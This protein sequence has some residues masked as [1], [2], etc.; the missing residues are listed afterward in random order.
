MIENENNFN[1][2]QQQL[3]T[4]IIGIA[5]QYICLLLNIWN[6]CLHNYSHYDL[7]LYNKYF[8]KK[9]VPKL[10]QSLELSPPF[11]IRFEIAPP[12]MICTFIL[13]F[14]QKKIFLMAVFYST[15]IRLGCLITFLLLNIL[16]VMIIVLP[17]YL[18]TYLYYH[19]KRTFDKGIII[20]N[21]FNVINFQGK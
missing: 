2:L 14:Q 9:L 3:N 21:F 19:W 13:F 11:Q 12:R 6:Y 7:G 20:I 17:T 16:T 18:P 1:F 15:E 10:F 8:S 5:Q 4:L